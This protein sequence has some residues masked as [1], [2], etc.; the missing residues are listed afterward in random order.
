MFK[1]FDKKEKVN[2]EFQNPKFIIKIKDVKKIFNSFYVRFI[3]II[4]PLNIFKRKKIDHLK[5]LIA[6]RLKYRIFDYSNS[7]S[8]RELII[9]LRQIDLNVKL[10]N[11]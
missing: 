2:V 5:K 6:N 4:A 7:I 8:Y 1:N 9:R 10:V 11:E 3:I